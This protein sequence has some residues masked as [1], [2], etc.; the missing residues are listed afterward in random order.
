MEG[1]GSDGMNGTNRVPT[2]PIPSPGNFLTDVTYQWPP[3]K[4]LTAVLFNSKR[5]NYPKYSL[6]EG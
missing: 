3:T 2:R 4:L 5:L 6:T 1:Q